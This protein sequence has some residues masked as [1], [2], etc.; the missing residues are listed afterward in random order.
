MLN[1]KN[2]NIKNNNF[3]IFS[4]NGETGIR[5]QDVEF[6]IQESGVRRQESDFRVKEKRP[7]FA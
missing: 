1:G 3:V 5:M 6:R 4:V 7:E 2:I